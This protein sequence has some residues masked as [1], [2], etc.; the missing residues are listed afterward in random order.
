MSDLDRLYEQFKQSTTDA[1]GFLIAEYGCTGPYVEES[2]TWRVVAY[3]NATTGV[4]V[5][6]D[7]RANG[8]F[9]Y[10]SRLV[11]DK[12]PHHFDAPTDRF[13]LDSIIALRSPLAEVQNRHSGGWLTSQDV[14]RAVAQYAAALRQYADDVL[15]GNFTVF[16]QLAE[17]VD[18]ARAH[19]ISPATSGLDQQLR[20]AM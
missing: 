19:S 9:V 10:L 4:E 5:V 14:K 20:S 3:K 13:L 2:A 8:I 1:F 6:L 11:N 18:R 16:D 7:A 17:R 12:I 15:R